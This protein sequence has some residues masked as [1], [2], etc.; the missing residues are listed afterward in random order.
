GGRAVVAA[1][2]GVA[3]GGGGVVLAH[4]V[5]PQGQRGDAGRAVEG[6][7]GVVGVQELPAVGPQQA[8]PVIGDPLVGAER[9]VDAVVVLGRV[10]QLDGVGF[11][12]G[13]GRRRPAEAGLGEVLLG[14]E[15]H[16]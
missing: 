4:Q 13:P 12:L 5:L 9:D 11:Q 6:G 14:V 8:L 16:V 3:G 10:G 15:Q 1:G 2:L 7:L